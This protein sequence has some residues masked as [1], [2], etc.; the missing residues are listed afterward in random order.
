[1]GRKIIKGFVIPA[2]AGIQILFS[3]STPEPK[4]LWIPVFTGMTVYS[5]FKWGSIR[6]A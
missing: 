3:E 2:K 6:R 5:S 1:M 4:Q